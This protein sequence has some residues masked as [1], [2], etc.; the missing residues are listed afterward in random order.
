MDIDDALRFLTVDFGLGEQEQEQEQDKAQDTVPSSSPTQPSPPSSCTND[1]NGTR[2]SVKKVEFSPCVTAHNH[3]LSRSELFKSS[4]LLKKAHSNKHLKPLKSILKATL[5][6]QTPTPDSTDSTSLD[7]F[8]VDKVKPPTLPTMLESVLKLLASPTPSLRLDGYR[9]LNGAL[10]AYEELPDV[11]LFKS[12]MPVL[13]KY[14][15]RDISLSPAKDDPISA[16]LIPQALKLA[17]AII[18]TPALDGCFPEDF[19]NL[20]LDRSMAAL[21]SEDASKMVVNHYMYLLASQRFSSRIMTPSKAEQIVNSLATIHDRVLGNGLTGARLVI[22]QRLIEQAP[23][24]MLAMIRSWSSHVFHGSISSV[25]DVR[26]RAVETGNQAALTLGIHYQATKAIIDL[27]NTSTNDNGTY[28]DFFTAK[29]SDMISQRDLAVHV[30]QVWSMVILFFRSRKRKLQTW[31]LFKKAWL[32]IIQRCMNSSDINVRFRATLAWNRLIF[33]VSPD[34]DAKETIPGIVN[35]LKIPFV[36][37]FESKKDKDKRSKEARS[38]AVSGYCH[39]LHYALRP[40]QSHAELDIY[41]EEYIQDVLPKLLRSGPKDAAL[42]FRVLKALFNGQTNVWDVDLANKSATIGPDDLPRLDPKWV[43]SR[44]QKI[45]HLFSPALSEYLI[46]PRQDCN[47]GDTAWEEFMTAIAEA[48]SQEV[49]ASTEF[50]EALAHLMNYFGHVWNEASK[51]SSG[52]M[53]DTWIARFGA[54]LDCCIE[55]TGP[56]QFSEECLVRNQAETFEAAPTPS[57]RPSKHHNVLHSPIVFLLS[58]FNRPPSSVAVNEA[59]FRVAADAIHRV[60]EAIPVRRRRTEV[61]RQC[62]QILSRPTDAIAGFNADV[63]LW[64]ILAHEAEVAL[65]NSGA[66]TTNQDPH[67]RG[68]QVRDVIHILKIGLPFCSIRPDNLS[69]WQNLFKTAATQLH[70]EAGDG[71]LIVGLIEPAAKVAWEEAPT[72]PVSTVLQTTNT[73]LQKSVWPRNRQQIDDGRRALGHTGLI[74]HRHGLSAPFEPFA[75]VVKLTNHALVQAYEKLD[76]SKQHSEFLV[77]Q[78]TKFLDTCPPLQLTSTLMKMQE[79][80]AKC[81]EDK[82]RKMVPT[83]DFHELS[84][85]VNSLWQRIL[86]LLRSQP[87]S[88]VLLKALESLWVAGLNSSH[89]AIVNST[90][91]F[92]NETFGQLNSL[93]YPSKVEVALRKIQPLVELELPGFPLATEE[94]VCLYNQPPSKN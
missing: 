76:E 91:A 27:F 75:N 51:S 6:D 36:S 42:A 89:R 40:S 71:A 59:F 46:S 33:V 49:R 21:E 63:Q 20:L 56:L 41:W 86:R 85:K 84:T 69:A 62:S 66:N 73:V 47:I 48:G 92:W 74:T 24:V 82:A 34:K 19:Q 50:R 11:R 65:N 94:S 12:K 25:K 81:V 17:T 16:T 29:L 31:P 35:M 60:C 22:Y 58:L 70:K 64:M 44:A 55:K 32:L 45:L 77:E 26:V 68:H 4:P 28:G 8:S 1:E 7:Y 14:I 54:L 87:S 3:G 61:L 10:K 9:T 38:I 13:V 90:V 5:S 43:R 72:L 79:G 23:S 52:H 67:H 78:S 88:N 93:E 83:N 57:Q 39:L 30:P 15:A 80:L 37:A 2:R 53:A 18:L